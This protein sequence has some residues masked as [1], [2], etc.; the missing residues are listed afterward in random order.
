[1]AQSSDQNITMGSRV[2]VRINSDEPRVLTISSE[3][4][5]PMNGIISHE[6]P[7]GQ[8]LL[9]AEVGATVSYLTATGKSCTV[10]I[11][12]VLS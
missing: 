3:K 10:E 12:E 7:L 11:L 6:C 5:D 9:G 2:R 1:M 4:P 8:T